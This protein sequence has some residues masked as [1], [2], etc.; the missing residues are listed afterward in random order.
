[1]AFSLLPAPKLSLP[2]Q[3]RGQSDPLLQA[4]GMR[5]QFYVTA[6]KNLSCRAPRCEDLTDC[7]EQ[8]LAGFPLSPSRL[9]CVLSVWH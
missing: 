1:M 2:G 5:S 6:F 7:R 8:P 4:T 3:G 9:P